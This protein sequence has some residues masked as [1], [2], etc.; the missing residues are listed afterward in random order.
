LRAILAGSIALNVA[1]AAGLA[2]MA[3]RRRK[4]KDEDEMDAKK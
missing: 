1:L 4:D 2:V 3:L